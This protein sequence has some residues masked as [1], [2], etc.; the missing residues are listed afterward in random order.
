M[1]N[2]H[3]SNTSQKRRILLSALQQGKIA[4]KRPKIELAGVMVD[5]NRWA[6]V[7]V[8]ISVTLLVLMVLLAQTLYYHRTHQKVWLIKLSPDGSATQKL[9]AEKTMPSY[10][11]ATLNTLMTHYVERRFS[12]LSDSVI[13]DYGFAYEFMGKRL[14]RQF[15]E[16]DKAIERAHQHL[17][18]AQCKQTRVSV[19]AI[20]HYE[21]NETLLHAKPTREYRSSVFVT[22]FIRNKAGQLLNKEKA[23]ITLVWRIRPLK[24]Y[25]RNQKA[26]L[27]D[28]IGLEILREHKKKAPLG[29]S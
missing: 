5:R 26:L 19:D 27:A 7:C 28:P 1:N 4:A 9:L 24:T 14:K 29:V 6:L 20:E 21:D 13:A 3:H 17:H 18:C 23:I 12:Q 11:L 16:E 2:N 22:S 10:Y 8:C 15:I 25:A